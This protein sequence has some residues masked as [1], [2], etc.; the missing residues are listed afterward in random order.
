[1]TCTNTVA[2]TS[3]ANNLLHS[4]PSLWTPY[5][6][7][8]WRLQA[9]PEEAL[10]R[11]MFQRCMDHKYEVQHALTLLQAPPEEVI[12]HTIVSSYGDPAATS[13]ELDFRKI[14]QH[15]SCGSVKTKLLLFQA[16]RWVRDLVCS[17]HNICC[18]CC[19]LALR[20]DLTSSKPIEVS[21]ASA[22]RYEIIIAFRAWSLLR[23]QFECTCNSLC[24]ENKIH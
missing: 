24:I 6:S 18:V 23:K 3:R 22:C 17:T 16:L 1:M 8:H 15:L 7:M 4:S 20:S 5:C 19:V 9:P 2:G 12:H 13:F 11:T 21:V 14:K 10:C